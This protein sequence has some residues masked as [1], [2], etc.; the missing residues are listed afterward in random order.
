MCPI[1]DFLYDGA[2]LLT[3][4]ATPFDQ[5]IDDLLHLLARRGCGSYLQ[6]DQPL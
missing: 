5:A 6:E 2:A 3:F 1:E 4:D